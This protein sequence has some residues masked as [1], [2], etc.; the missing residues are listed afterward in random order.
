MNQ[1][2]N[3]RHNPK[4]TDDDL[5]FIRNN[6]NSMTLHDIASHLNRSETSIKTIMS[7]YGIYKCK[8]AKHF[9]NQIFSLYRQGYSIRQTADE[10]GLTYDSVSYFAK[11][12]DLH[13]LPTKQ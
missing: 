10:L 12:H 3:T 9:R 2:K 5:Q 7:Q 11:K 13:F 4:Y 1:Q 8:S 6:I